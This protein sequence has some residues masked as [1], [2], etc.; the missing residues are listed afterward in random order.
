MLYCLCVCLEGIKWEHIQF[1][2][3][4]D[5]L[6]LLAAKP[7]NLIALIDEESRFP[8]VSPHSSH[9]S[10]THPLHFTHAHTY[11]QT[12]LTHFTDLHT[13]LTHLTQGTDLSMLKKLHNQHHKHLH[14]LKPVSDQVHA[15]GIQ[16]FA[17]TVY[18]NAS[19]FLEKNRDTFS[20]DLFDLLNTSS[21][22]FIK[23]LFSGEKAMVSIHPVPHSCVCVCAYSTY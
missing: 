5:I 12:L 23:L 10:C 17:G 15:F 18:Y 2:D 8:K 11:P 4:Q 20:N 1:V 19:G 16:H 3:N 14:Y 7:L 13:L 9:T 22:P 6:D 21:S